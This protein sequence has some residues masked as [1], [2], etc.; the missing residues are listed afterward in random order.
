MSLINRIGRMP[1]YTSLG[2]WTP[3]EIK[4]IPGGE[5]YSPGIVLDSTNGYDGGNTGFERELRPGWMLAQITATK[6]FVPVKRTRANGAGSTATALIVDNAAAFRAG[7][8]LTVGANATCTISSINYTTNT[9]TL[10]A[11]KT[12]S[13][14]AV[15]YCDSLPGSETALLVLDGWAK[16]TLDDGTTLSDAIAGTDPNSRVLI[17]GYLIA[18]MLLGD[19]ASVQADTANVVFNKI[20]LDTDYGFVN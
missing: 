8:T 18:A 15:V 4:W 19:V 2:S 10:A 17:E 6:K 14:N 5:V 11:T 7:E 13:D 3:R 9:I 1:G 20:S 12:W 16:L